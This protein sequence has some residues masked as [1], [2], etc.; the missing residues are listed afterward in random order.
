LCL[1]GQAE[2]CSQ[3]YVDCFT[4]L[5][6]AQLRDTMQRY[7]SVV[8]PALAGVRAALGQ[9]LPEYPTRVRRLGYAR[10]AGRRFSFTNYQPWRLHRCRLWHRI[11]A[12]GTRLPRLHRPLGS[13]GLLGRTSGLRP[14]VRALWPMAT[15]T[16]RQRSVGAEPGEGRPQRTS[17]ARHSKSVS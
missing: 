12:Q 10:R 14:C 15:V 5:M 2:H 1:E 13:K 11:N 9:G 3:G 6:P 16:L 8:P 17:P 4:Q 7:S